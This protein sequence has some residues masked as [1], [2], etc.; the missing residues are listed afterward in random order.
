M[1]TN[2]RCH[3]CIT[4]DPK[5]LRCR[6]TQACSVCADLEKYVEPSKA[7]RRKEGRKNWIQ[8]LPPAP[9]PSYITCMMFQSNLFFPDSRWPK[10]QLRHSSAQLGG[11]QT[12][13]LHLQHQRPSPSHRAA[14]LSPCALGIFVAHVSGAESAT[15]AVFSAQ[16]V[17]QQ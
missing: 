17:G 12:I 15:A 13:Q 2:L 4:G 5:S 10:L 3:Y 7:K 11:P 14:Y 16:L 6:K 1:R 8:H 9:L